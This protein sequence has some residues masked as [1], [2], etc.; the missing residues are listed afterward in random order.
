MNQQSTPQQSASQQQK[1]GMHESQAAT[2]QTAPRQTTAESAA[3]AS[4]ER[5]LHPGMANASKGHPAGKMPGL[6][7]PSQLHDW[8]ALSATGFLGLTGIAGMAPP[9]RK[10]DARKHSLFPRVTTSAI[11]T[12]HRDP[13][14]SQASVTPPAA[15]AAP[16]PRHQQPLPAGPSTPTSAAAEVLLPDVVPVPQEDV[17]SAVTIASRVKKMLGQLHQVKSENMRKLRH[18]KKRVH[19]NVDDMINISL[20]LASVLPRAAKIRARLD[21]GLQALL[22][23]RESAPAHPVQAGNK[24]SPAATNSDGNSTSS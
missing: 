19:I 21:H 9:P 20:D 8:G 18:C 4:N 16:A 2:G 1:A 24:E 6:L 17:R 22:R 10:A 15:P 11:P 12:T 23:H 14:R 7:A 13:H 3:P 5:P